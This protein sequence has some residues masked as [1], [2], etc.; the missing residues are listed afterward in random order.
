M[1]VRVLNESEHTVPN[2]AISVDSFS[3][4]E[5]YPELAANKRPIWVV[6][7]GP[8]TPPYHGWLLGYNASTGNF[9]NS[10]ALGAG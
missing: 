10:V 7:E 6:E 2:V 8:G 9:T 3:Y 4:V 5:K 1:T